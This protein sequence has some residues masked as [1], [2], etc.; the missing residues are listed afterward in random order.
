M[1]TAS[2]PSRNHLFAALPGSV[3]DCILPHMESSSLTSGRVVFEANDTLRHIYFPVDAIVSL[4][5]ETTKGASTEI[6]MVGNDGVL[7]VNAFLGGT[8]TTHRAI[9]QNAGL[10]Y[11]I[12]TFQLKEEL[13]RQRE[14]LSFVL[15]YIQCLM[16]QVAQTAVC[17]RHHIIEQ[18]FSRLLLLSLDRVHSN[19]LN[20]TQEQFAAMLGVRRE[21]VTTAAQKL[22]NLGVIS[23]HRGHVTV[24]DRA[25]L[26]ELSCECYGVVKRE[27]ERI[28]PTSLKDS[29]RKVGALQT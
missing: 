10:A 1:L 16:T 20:M 9:V 21:S 28:L 22:Q 15:R 7:G 26:E 14:A 4:T 24:H 11:R 29:P 27:A 18:Q 6:A 17:N 12:P 13:K 8:T 5:Y 19:E 25:S 2:A 3:Q 23:Y